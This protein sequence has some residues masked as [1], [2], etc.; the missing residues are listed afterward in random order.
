MSL[1]LYCHN[2][3]HRFAL[4]ASEPTRPELVKRLGERFKQPCPSCLAVRQYHVN[5]VTKR[6]PKWISA[7]VHGSLLAV[8]GGLILYGWRIGAP[9]GWYFSI[10]IPASF[11]LG[12]SPSIEVNEFSFNRYRI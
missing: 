10:M 5:Q 8:A 3:R 6:V 11:G 2:C 4:K 12:I 7:V 1:L 9:Y